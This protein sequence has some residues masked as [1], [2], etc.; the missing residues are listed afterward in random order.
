MILRIALFQVRGPVPL[1]TVKFR[2]DLEIQNLNNP[3]VGSPILKPYI[4]PILSLFPPSQVRSSSA[5]GL[6]PNTDNCLTLLFNYY[7]GNSFPVFLEADLEIVRSGWK[8]DEE[9]RPIRDC[10]QNRFTFLAEYC[11]GHLRRILPALV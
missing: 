1:M 9:P 10:C 3:V 8:V 7:L 6:P 11:Y 4:H 5:P 2:I